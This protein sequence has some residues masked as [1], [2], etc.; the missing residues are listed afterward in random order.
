MIVINKLY[1]VLLGMA[2]EDVPA[3]YR[4]Y[5]KKFTTVATSEKVQNILKV[6]L[7]TV[8]MD[9]RAVFA[10]LVCNAVLS[11]VFGSEIKKLDSVNT[12]VPVTRPPDSA[13]SNNNFCLVTLTEPASS[14]AA[15][16]QYLDPDIKEK[17]TA[18]VWIEYIAAG[19]LQI[20][21]ELKNV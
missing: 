18:P 10:C 6:L 13:D 1:G 12:Y 9:K 20:L 3:D 17:L 14:Y 21:R 7:K 4:W 16:L 15:L 2:A 5:I 11:T 19:C 8:P